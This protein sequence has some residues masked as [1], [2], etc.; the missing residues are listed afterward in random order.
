MLIRDC[1]ICY[2]DNPGWRAPKPILEWWW[3]RHRRSYKHRVAFVNSTGQE[4]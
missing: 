3:R 2:T 4:I 1:T